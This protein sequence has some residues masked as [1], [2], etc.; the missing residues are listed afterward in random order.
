[1][2]TQLVLEPPALLNPA[3]A[4]QTAKPMA[5][6]AEQQQHTDVQAQQFVQSLLSADMHS[7]LFKQQ[8]DNAFRAG[9]REI[10]DAAELLSGRF[11]QRNFVGMEDSAAFATI[12][13]LRD[14]FAQFNPSG[15]DLLGVDKLFGLIPFG[16]RL[17][18]YFRKYQSAA[19][20]I[21]ILMEKL[22]QAEDEMRKDVAEIEVLKG[23]LWHSL[24]R[25]ET[26][27]QFVEQVD[28]QISHHIEQVKLT[29]SHKARVL[30]QEVLFYVR[31]NHSDVLAQKTVTVNAYL[32]MDILRKTAREM[33]NGCDRV[34]TLGMSALATAQ[35]VARAT[36]NQI[37]VMELLRGSAKGIEDLITG[38]SQM[39][40][41]QVQRT[42]ELSQNPLIGVQ[43]LQSAID[44]TLKAMDNL[45]N[46]RSQALDHMARNNQ[47]L[48]GLVEHAEHSIEQRRQVVAEY[49][50]QQPKE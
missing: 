21:R 13:Q 28:Q 37:Q 15:Q 27:A 11:M 40:G 2:T 19:S 43:A 44:N 32:S 42:A 30:E 25:L 49:R 39:L 46:F 34:A 35:T 29:D 18:R 31:Q 7:E 8:V 38:T 50:S 14:V 9:R 5:L 1:M 17:Q 36:G 45:D 48:R 47:T 6:N 16:N 23:R 41:Q 10:S 20:H 26:A 22:A 33:I 12:N 24:Q 4:E 3:S